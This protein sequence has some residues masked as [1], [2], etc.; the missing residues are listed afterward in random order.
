MSPNTPN[1]QT[2]DY[3]LTSIRFSHYAEKVRWTLDRL[4]IPYRERYVLPVTH[5]FV[6]PF[7]VRGAGRRDSQSTRFSTPILKTEEGQ[8]ISKSSAIMH[9]LSD[10]YLNKEYSLF[11]SQEVID[12]DNR[13]NESLGPATRCILYYYLLNKPDIMFKLADHSAGP[14]QGGL[15]KLLY[16]L[17]RRL[18]AKALKINER[19]AEQSL[20][21]VFQAYDDVALMLSDG[22]RFLFDDRLTAADISFACLGGILTLPT[23]QEGYAACLPSIT[24]V[25]PKLADIAGQLRSHK[26]GQWVLSLFREQRGQRVIPGKPLLPD[27]SA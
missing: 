19:Q 17:S 4:N 18:M 20:K 24:E 14:I 8:V 16:P 7:I 5:F 3:T 26:T 22:R 21:Q 6:T 2:T 9:Y 13:F 25:D 15:Y 12:L 11:P 1:Q 23:A 27:T 10:R